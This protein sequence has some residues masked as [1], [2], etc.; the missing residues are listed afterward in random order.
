LEQCLINDATIEEQSAR[1]IMQHVM[2]RPSPKDIYNRHGFLPLGILE[3]PSY[4]GRFFWCSACQKFLSRDCF[5]GKR[6]KKPDTTCYVCRAVNVHY[7]W[8][9]TW[10]KRAEQF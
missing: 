8:M 10:S 9:Q 7:V 3:Q 6:G 2:A 5:P 4:C 1:Y